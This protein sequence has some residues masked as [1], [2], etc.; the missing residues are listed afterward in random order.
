MEFLP[1][2]SG[3]NGW[4]VSYGSHIIGD[5]N[6]ATV[7]VAE[8]DGQRNVYVLEDG[9]YEP[10]AGVHDLLAWDDAESEWV[11]TS[12]GQWRLIFDDA[13]RLREIHDSA[14]N[15]STVVRDSGENYRIDYVTSARRRIVIP[16][17]E[18]DA[19]V[20]PANDRVDLTRAERLGQGRPLG[21][22]ACHGVTVEMN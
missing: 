1:F 16:L 11:L 21:L 18:R 4:S 2:F 19:N 6:D 10:P 12:P 14:G 5:P 15:V 8:A 20:G 17:L 7:V 9:I 3:Y 13:G 22:A